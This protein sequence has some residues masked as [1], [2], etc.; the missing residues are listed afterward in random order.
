MSKSVGFTKIFAELEYFS[1]NTDILRRMRHIWGILRRVFLRVVLTLRKE[2][3]IMKA[4]KRTGGKMKRIED[5]KI[6]I[7]DYDLFTCKELERQFNGIDNVEI[8]HAKIESFYLKH[9][10]EVDCLVSPANAFGYMTGGYDA[11]LSD[12]LGWDFQ[13]KVRDYI[14][15]NFYG[16]QGVGTSFIID[17]DFP[18]LRLIHTPTMQYPSIIHDDM[19]VYYCMRST[20]ICALKNDVNCIVIPVFGGACGQVDPEISSKRMKD[21]YLQI[22]H[23]VGAKYEF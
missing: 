18:N 17:T 13:Y 14:K 21:A 10:N 5:L 9:K 11:A 20:L 15:R 16:E 6:Y 1:K 3:N 12:I 19:I 22:L 4:S 23:R 8:V 2:C 7:V